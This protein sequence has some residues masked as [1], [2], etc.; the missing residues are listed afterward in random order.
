[1]WNRVLLGAFFAAFLNGHP[2]AFNR[3][4]ERRRSFYLPANVVRLQGCLI[5]ELPLSFHNKQT[6]QE[7]SIWCVLSDV[8]CGLW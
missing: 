5:E 3:V 4:H 7:A 1:M 2:K 8:L 6:V